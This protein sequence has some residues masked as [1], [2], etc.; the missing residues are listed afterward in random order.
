MGHAS[1][2]H[3][4]SRARVAPFQCSPTLTMDK[5]AAHARGPCWALLSTSLEH[6]PWEN[7]DRGAVSRIIDRAFPGGSSRIEVSG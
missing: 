3:M 1:S 7:E 5:S 6:D 2:I 4:I